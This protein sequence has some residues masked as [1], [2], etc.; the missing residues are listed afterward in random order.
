MRYLTIN[1][2]RQFNQHQSVWVLNNTKN[3]PV[4]ARNIDPETHK[5]RQ[6]RADVMLIV[7]SVSGTGEPGEDACRH[8]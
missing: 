7:P 5:L 3:A 6:E 1:D 4:M 8:T 2:I